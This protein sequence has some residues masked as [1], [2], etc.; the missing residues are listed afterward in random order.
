VISLQDRN[1]EK[2]ALRVHGLEFRTR[3][4]RKTLM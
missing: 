3:F 1:R 4:H 2:A